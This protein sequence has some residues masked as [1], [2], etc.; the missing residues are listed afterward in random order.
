MMI[1]IEKSP[2]SIRIGGI[3]GQGNIKMGLILAKALTYDKKWVIQTQHY[4]AQVRGGIA[5]SDVLF[6][7][8]PIDYPV[9]YS[10]DILYMMHQKSL[11]Q[12]YKLVKPNGILFCDSTFVNKI[13]VTVRRLTRKII[14]FPV[15]EISKEKFGMPVLANVIGLGLLQKTTEIVSMDS[16][17]KTVLEE[18]PERF[19]DLNLQ[20]LEYGYSLCEKSYAV[21]EKKTYTPVNFE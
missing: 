17:K 19:K 15:A 11:D 18:V 20:A 2:N 6:C 7:S 1:P 21:K 5:Y 4:G 14:S 9:A 13:P 16:L 3:G 10:F 8:D 12:Y